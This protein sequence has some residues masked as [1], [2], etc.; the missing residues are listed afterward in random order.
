[1]S[2]RGTTDRINLTIKY[3]PPRPQAVSS[4]PGQGAAVVLI[5]DTNTDKSQ[6]AGQQAPQRPTKQPNTIMEYN[7]Q[8]NTQNMER[9]WDSG[10]TITEEGGAVEGGR[11]TMEE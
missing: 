4:A 10:N 2:N 7:T 9:L 1:M 6:P 8:N 5:S 3:P 11:V